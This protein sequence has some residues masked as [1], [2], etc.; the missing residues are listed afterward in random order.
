MASNKKSPAKTK[1][2]KLS[3]VGGNGTTKEER[4]PKPKPKPKPKPRPRK[5]AMIGSMGTKKPPKKRTKKA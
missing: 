5:V 3:M 2:K 4:P 1:A